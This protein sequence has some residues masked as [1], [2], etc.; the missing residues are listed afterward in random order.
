M[1]GRRP[2]REDQVMGV[3]GRDPPRLGRGGEG[4]DQEQGRKKVRPHLRGEPLRVVDPERQRRLDLDHVVVGPV[5]AQ[6]HAA[7]A[8]ALDEPSR[9]TTIGERREPLY[10]RDAFGVK[11]QEL[12]VL[13]EITG[14]VLD[15]YFS[16][17]KIA[18]LLDRIPGARERAERRQTQAETDRLCALHRQRLESMEPARR[19]F[20]ANEQGDGRITLIDG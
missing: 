19:V 20:Y 12:G 4:P 15:P 17:T 9:F 10:H 16:A 7:R 2:D 14:L 11:L 1:L 6:P 5:R 3:V 18:W 13:N 8:H